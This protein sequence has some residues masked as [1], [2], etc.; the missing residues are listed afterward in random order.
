MLALIEREKMKRLAKGTL[1]IATANYSSKSA[2]VCW[3]TIKII[4][5]S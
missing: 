3:K 1:V 4:L 2:G 5:M